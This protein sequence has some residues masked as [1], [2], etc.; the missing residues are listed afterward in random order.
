MTRTLA[1]ALALLAAGPA[2]AL[3]AD[4]TPSA[5]QA[6][7]LPVQLGPNARERY[8]DIFA[9]IRAERWSDAST[10]LDA[11]DKG[12]LH[13][14][15][16][17]LIYTAKGSP[18]VEAPALVILAT[19][20]PDLPQSQA[21]VR[22]AGARGAETVPMLPEV[23]ELRWLGT[24]PRRARTAATGGDPAAGW[25]A[26]QIIPLI[27]DDRPIDAEAVLVLNE[28]RL[29]PDARTEWRQRVAWSYFIGGDDA[30]ARALAATARNATGEWAAMADWVEGLAAWRQKD[31]PAASSAFASVARRS[32]DAEMI[33]AGHYWAARADI[34]LQQ[35]ER[36]QPHLRNAARLQETFYGMLA[37]AAMGLAPAKDTDGSAAL[38][39]VAERPNVRTALALAEIGELDRADELLRWQARIGV[40]V[41]HAALTLIAGRINLPQT[42]LYL[43]HNGPSGARTTIE[44]RY[45][46]PNSWTPEGG[47][48]ID[49]ALVFAHTL[50]ESR[51]QANA[52]S[53]A[54]A[55]GLMQVMPATAQYIARRK[56]VALVGSL[57][58]PAT[59][60][61]Y[62]Q[63][64]LEQLRDMT[65]T[66]GLLPKVIMAYNA[67]PAPLD[68]WNARDA[69]TLNDP[70]LYIESVSYW[71]T[72][73]YVT[74]VLRNYW[75]YQQQAGSKTESLTS[76][77]QGLW[78]RFPGMTPARPSR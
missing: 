73:G 76:L 13:A 47:W 69:T 20:A 31:W 41:E 70:L 44:G 66:G 54:G 42:Q 18:R 29:T 1:M 74:T 53:P 45:P 8:R 22:L 55:R 32:S 30:R 38:R 15:A 5:A 65:Q 35:P 9:S 62:G 46:M 17:A 43:A 58:S 40:P 2:P 39:K 19:E 3:A 27:K 60:M 34:V 56:G 4:T 63:T 57:T 51:F 12:P 33:A 24:S 67:G 77:V 25:M 10:K 36:V 52:V 75:M 16:R 11:M 78:P 28:D 72:R 6:T 68:R 71:E 50:Q 7:V 37:H 59:N 23:R 14:V 61:E 26:A 48:R 49:R 64:Y 21:L